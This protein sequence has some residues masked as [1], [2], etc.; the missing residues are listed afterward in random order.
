MN[1][2]SCSHFHFRFDYTSAY[3]DIAN[4]IFPA[5]SIRNGRFTPGMMIN[6]KL[7]KCLSYYRSSRKLFQDHN[8]TYCCF[9]LILFFVA[10]V[11]PNS[12]EAQEDLGQFLLNFSQEHGQRVTLND[13]DK[14]YISSAIRPLV[15]LQNISSRS[16]RRWSSLC[17]TCNNILHFKPIKYLL[18]FILQLCYSPL[19]ILSTYIHTIFSS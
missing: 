14:Y 19:H 7:S 15:N 13:P 3:D 9:L 12:E 18:Y 1:I 11:C 4:I 8:A 16:W 5:N 10:G 17:C 6:I 2:R